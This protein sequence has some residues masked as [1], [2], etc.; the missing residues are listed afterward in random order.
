MTIIEFYKKLSKILTDAREE[1][2]SQKEAEDKLQ[3]LMNEAKESNL[4]IDINPSILDPVNL[5]RL[6]DENSFRPSDDDDFSYDDEGY[7]SSY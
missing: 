6:D 3:I 2:L 5:M 7:E 1:F 4:N